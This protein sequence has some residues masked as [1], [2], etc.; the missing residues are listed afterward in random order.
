MLSPVTFPVHSQIRARKGYQGCE[1]EWGQRTCIR[2]T[3][4]IRIVTRCDA[5]ELDSEEGR[6]KT[7]RKRTMM[8]KSDSEPR[9]VMIN[10][11]MSLLPLHCQI[12]IPVAL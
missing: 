3:A 7:Q 9:F 10:E 5:T 4:L 1:D 8:M 2:R 6:R 12:V 11:Q